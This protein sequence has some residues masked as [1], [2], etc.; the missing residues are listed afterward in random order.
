MA[1]AVPTEV[2]TELPGHEIVA[3]GLQDLT[4]GRLTAEA[5][6]TAMAAPRLRRLGLHVPRCPVDVPGHRLY[7][8]LSADD[9][10]SAHSRYNALIGRVVSYARAAEHASAR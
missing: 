3:A 4:A 6:V 1:H 10:R 7:D 5:L 8:L 9:G 2:R